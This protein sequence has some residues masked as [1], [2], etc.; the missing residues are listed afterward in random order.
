MFERVKTALA[1]LTDKLAEVGA[2]MPTATQITVAV[3]GVAV[4]VSPAAP[5]PP[6]TC[7]HCGVARST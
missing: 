5:K 2:R 4:T 7:A 6:T 3:P 1:A